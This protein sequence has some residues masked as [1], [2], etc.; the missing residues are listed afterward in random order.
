MI[1][2]VAF[3]IVVLIVIFLLSVVVS[4]LWPKSQILDKAE[5]PHDTQHND[6]KLVGIQY[7]NTQHNDTKLVG[8]QRDTQL[9]DIQHN[10]E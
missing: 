8:I 5:W 1:L 2:N 7:S 10:N 4:S 6:T 9:I 3:F